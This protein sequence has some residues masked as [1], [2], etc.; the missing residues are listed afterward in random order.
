MN[1]R[2]IIEVDGGTINSITT[3][4]E[5][6]EVL[7][8]D[9]DTEAIDP[10]NVHILTKEGDEETFWFEHWGKIG[11]NYDENIE[12]RISMI[13]NSPTIGFGIDNK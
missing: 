3:N 13:L 6:L 12:N 1:N 5:E 2:I 9:F 11:V 7:V 10:E 8:V 4:D